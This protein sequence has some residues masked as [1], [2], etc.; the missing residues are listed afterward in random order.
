MLTGKRPFEP[1]SAVN[2]FTLQ[3]QGVQISPGKLRP[4]LPPKVDELLLAALEFDAAKRPQNVRQFGLEL[5]NLLRDGPVKGVGHGAPV[6]GESSVARHENHIAPTVYS[7]PNESIVERRIEYP[8]FEQLTQARTKPSKRPLLWALLAM[9]ILAAIAV[10][11]G[12]VIWNANRTPANENSSADAETGTA[13][14]EAK[15]SYFLMVQK[16]RDGK[17]FEAPFQ[18]SGQET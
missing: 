7:V 9:L 5:A 18:S 16:M 17:P 12:I 1:N 4:E 14:T 10:P 6:G 3:Q 15:L 11:A 8:E 13:K 2:M